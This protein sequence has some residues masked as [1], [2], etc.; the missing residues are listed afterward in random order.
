MGTIYHVAC[1][2]QAGTLAAVE[3]PEGRSW[4]DVTHWYVKWDTLHVLFSDEKEMAF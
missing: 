1:T 2:Y 3:F 4:D